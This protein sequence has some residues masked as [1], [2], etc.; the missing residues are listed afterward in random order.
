MDAN[1]QD[2]LDSF[3]DEEILEELTNKSY[4]D[5]NIEAA[6]LWGKR[7]CISFDYAVDSRLTSISLG[8]YENGLEY[9]KRA[10]EF[11]ASTESGEFLTKMVNSINKHKN[12]AFEALSGSAEY[13]EEEEN[14]EGDEGQELQETTQQGEEQ[15]EASEAGTSDGGASTEGSSGESNQEP[16]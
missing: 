6:L 4:V 10:L 9:A 12:A 1:E 11:A 15:N 16:K 2:L 8:N 14:A 13:Q 5:L 3:N 7:A